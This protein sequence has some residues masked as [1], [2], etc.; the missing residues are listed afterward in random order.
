MTDNTVVKISNQ[1][2]FSF[3]FFFFFYRNE[4][5]PLLQIEVEPTSDV[6]FCPSRPF[7]F[8]WS[9]LECPDTGLKEGRST[10]LHLSLLKAL[11]SQ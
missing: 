7:R 10:A 3:D 8:S 2:F 5:N 6:S 1:C 4:G 11:S 9:R